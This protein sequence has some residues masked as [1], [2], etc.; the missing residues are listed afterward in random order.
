MDLDVI[1]VGAGPTGLLLAAELALGGVGVEVID[2]LAE[3]DV[4]VK[5]ASIRITTAEMLDRRGLTSAIRLSC[6][7]S[8]IFLIRPLSPPFLTM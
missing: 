3:P 8:T 4:T 7:S 5:S 6:A 2:R 1:V